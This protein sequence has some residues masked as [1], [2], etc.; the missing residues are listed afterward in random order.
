MRLQNKM[1]TTLIQPA[2]A[3]SFGRLITLNEAA[4]LVGVGLKTIYREI[5]RGKF[6]KPVKIGAASR[7]SIHDVEA[8]VESLRAVK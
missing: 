1:S 6:P 4:A 8:Y 2:A 7:I 3:P 5:Q